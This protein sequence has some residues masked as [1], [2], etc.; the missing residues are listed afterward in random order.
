[1]QQSSLAS[2]CAYRQSPERPR[3]GLCLLFSLTA[4][5]S[6]TLALFR[7]L[8][9]RDWDLA[10]VWLLT[11]PLVISVCL[12]PYHRRAVKWSVALFGIV[13]FV[14][15][16]VSVATCRCIHGAC[17]SQCSNNLKQ[18]SLALQNYAAI[19]GSFPPAYML[20]QDGKPWH[21][22]R[23]LILPYLEQQPL[24]NA[25]RFDEPWNGPHNMALAAAM[26]QIYRC[27]SEPSAR[28][29][30]FHTSYVAIVGRGTAWPDT[31][32]A[33]LDDFPDG[34]C[35]TLL[36]VE[37][38]DSG[39]CWMQP[40]DL[41]LSALSLRVGAPTGIRSEHK[42][43]AWVATADGAVHFLPNSA[44]GQQV[45]AL[46]TTAGGERLRFFPANDR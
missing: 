14:G 8:G 46:I 4:A 25:Y 23:I 41:S 30:G 24:Y 3:Y 6:A 42:S 20:G 34:I 40:A 2:E 21:S 15:S 13:M 31:D 12:I 1:M 36:V 10:G 37:A 28:P 43:G 7:W 9:S 19:H 29:G 32:T 5:L 27:P 16:C 35:N 18:I 11:A 22:W 33:G 44:R 39:I 45:Q 38:S 26:P 17:K